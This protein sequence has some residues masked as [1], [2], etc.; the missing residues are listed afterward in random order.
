MKKI[1][2]ELVKS[3]IGTPKWM[4]TIVHTLALRKLH[5]K[6][7][8]NDSPSIRGMVKKVPHLVELTELEG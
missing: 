2:L 8:V 3:V 6:V 1:Q 5:S 4:R 7:V